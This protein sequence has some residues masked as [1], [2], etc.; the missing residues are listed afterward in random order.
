MRVWRAR[1]E[2]LTQLGGKMATSH[3]EDRSRRAAPVSEL[4]RSLVA[5]AVLLVRREAELA[6]IELKDKASKVAA[7]ASMFVAAAAIVLFA[8]AT[9]I[10]AAV[11]ALAI[12]L[13]AWAAALIVAALLL[14]VAAALV[15]AGRASIRAATPLAPKATLDTAQEDIAWMRH[16]TEQLKSAE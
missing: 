8:I 14:V 16:K 5:D 10:V 7:G 6:A 2:Q 11:L 12:V 15:L 13:P 9:L 3:T 4:V 1:P